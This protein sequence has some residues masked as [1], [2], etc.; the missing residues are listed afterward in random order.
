VAIWLQK[1]ELVAVNKDQQAHSHYQHHS[2]DPELNIRQDG[3]QCFRPASWLL[4]HGHPL[5]NL[6]INVT[7]YEKLR[8]RPNPEA[9]KKNPSSFQNPSKKGLSV[10]P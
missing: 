5:F 6:R 2:R 1:D 7:D 8:Y 3:A 10:R 4:V 9:V